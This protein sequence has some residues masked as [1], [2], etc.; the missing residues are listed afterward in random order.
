MKMDGAGYYY[1]IISSGHQMNALSDNRMQNEQSDFYMK[2]RHLL[3]FSS[4]SFRLL[5][6]KDSYG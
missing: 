4:A 3:R 1:S 5:A 2:F 6:P